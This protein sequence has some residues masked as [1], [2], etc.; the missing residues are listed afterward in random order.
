MNATRARAQI[1]AWFE[2]DRLDATRQ[3]C[4]AHEQVDISGP[5]R[6]LDDRSVTRVTKQIAQHRYAV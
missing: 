2:N 3:W 5:Y 6:T 4:R 1:V